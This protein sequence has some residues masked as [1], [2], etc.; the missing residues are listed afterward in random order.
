MEVPIFDTQLAVYSEA[1][2]LAKSPDDKRLALAGLARVANPRA[3]ELAKKLEA[4]EA[5]K[6]EAKQ[7]IEQI[8]KSL[9]K[10]KPNSFELH[11]SRARAQA[12]LHLS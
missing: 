3:L 6:A 9:E 7:A 12:F 11:G 8:S 2:A 5:V 4:D 10:S 1:L